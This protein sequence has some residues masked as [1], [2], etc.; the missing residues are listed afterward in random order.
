MY[1]QGGISSR[2]H[3]G[4]GLPNLYPPFVAAQGAVGYLSGADRNPNLSL[5]KPP[6]SREQSA[7]SEGSRRD[8]GVSTPGS[9]FPPPAPTAS[10]VE[11]AMAMGAPVGGSFYPQ[12]ASSWYEVPDPYQQQGFAGQHGYSDSRGVYTS[13][14]ANGESSSDF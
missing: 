3:T 11:A 8:L 2:V 1:Q 6:V 12:Q 13:Y 9:Y 4:V 10:A 14:R 5:D 7:P